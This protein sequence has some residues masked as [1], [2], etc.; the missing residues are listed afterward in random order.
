MSCPLPA[1]ARVEAVLVGPSHALG[2]RLFAPIVEH[3][4]RRQ[5]CEEDHGACGRLNRPLDDHPPRHLSQ[6]L[7]GHRTS[8]PIN[9]L[10][11]AALTLTD[12]E[13]GRTD[14]RPCAS[15]SGTGGG[16]ASLRRVTIVSSR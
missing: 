10:P 16:R 14:R 9:H 3:C 6:V 1:W 8:S 12:V 13:R 11:Y 4:S 15:E 5:T 2:L 7:V